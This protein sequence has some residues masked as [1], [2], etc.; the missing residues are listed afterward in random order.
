MTREIIIFGDGLVSQG[1][2][3]TINADDNSF[4][5]TVFGHE[6]FALNS[7]DNL[8]L[9]INRR[10]PEAIILAIAA[11][12][13]IVGHLTWAK[14][15]EIENQQINEKLLQILCDAPIHKLYN[16]V[17]G[18]V[19]PS[20]AD[21][22]S[23]KPIDLGS[24]TLEPSSELFAKNQIE[25][26]KL[27]GEIAVENNSWI[28]LVV[29]NVIGVRN[30]KNKINHHVLPALIDSITNAKSK[31]LNKV[32]MPGSGSTVRD[33]IWNQDLGMIMKKLLE[34]DLVNTE[35]KSV[36]N[37]AGTGPITIE[38]LSKIVSDALNFT[39]E[40]LFEEQKS[41]T[42]TRYKLLQQSQSIN[43]LDYSLTPLTESI[44]S[45]VVG[46]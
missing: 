19:Y 12:S 17:P 41:I 5:L 11:T 29:T 34:V 28:N 7:I 18:C 43:R 40:I 24:G 44:K 32:S 36:L 6:E 10:R 39:G 14:E 2:Q 37:I 26:M 38:Q 46:N 22:R 20:N 30:R 13:G 16:F 21:N 4:S 27:L 23:L 31:G 9:C 35:E 3:K 45:I 15:I 33:F 25:R 8:K 1:I 42:G